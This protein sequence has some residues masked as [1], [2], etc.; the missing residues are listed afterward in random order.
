M[1]TIITIFSLAAIVAA[2]VPFGPAPAGCSDYELIIGILP[3]CSE[4]V[5]A[6]QYLLFLGRG[7]GEPGPFGKIVGDPLMAQVKR[8]LPEARGY[9]VQY[10]AALSEKSVVSG[11]NDIINRITNQAKACPKQKFALAGYS[12]GARIIRAAMKPMAQTSPELFDKIVAIATYGDAGSRGENAKQSS[13]STPAPP[14][15]PAALQSKLLV[16]CVRGDAVSYT[17]ILLLLLWLLWCNVLLTVV[18][19][20]G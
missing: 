3:Q 2:D 17:C 19:I 14:T 10:I 12:Q 15:L 8:L 13:P 4:N 9:A 5:Q 1:K 16:N 18:Y 6:N 20:S 11:K 7:T